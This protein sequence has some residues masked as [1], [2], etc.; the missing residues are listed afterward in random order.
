M[1]EHRYNLIDVKYNWPDYPFGEAGRVQ[2]RWVQALSRN[3]RFP[4]GEY[5]TPDW[6][7]IVETIYST[8]AL[9]T[10]NGNQPAAACTRH[11]AAYSPHNKRQKKNQQT[12]EK[13]IT[14][15]KT[16]NLNELPI[17]GNLD[18]KQNNHPVTVLALFTRNRLPANGSMYSTH[19]D[20]FATYREGR[21]NPTNDRK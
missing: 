12:T 10:R 18:E 11:V 6:L 20:V 17:T 15:Q 14:I 5:S 9:F 19:V 4:D 16:R 8:L 21:K 2:P 7:N 1:Q 3:K 13:H